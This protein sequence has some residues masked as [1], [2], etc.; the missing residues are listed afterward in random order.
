MSLKFTP[1]VL[2][3]DKIAMKLEPE[4]SELDYSMTVTISS[5]TIAGLLTRNMSTHLEVQD[6]Q[7]I[8]MAGL[9]SNEDRN[10]VNKFPWAGGRPRFGEPVPFQQLAEAGNRAGGA[11]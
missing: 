11:W 1:T 7:T 6:G 10:I 9:L 2:D 8:A 5:F 4:V 3:G